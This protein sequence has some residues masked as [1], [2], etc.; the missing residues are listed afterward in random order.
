VRV[1]VDEDRRVGGRPVAG[2]E[3]V[4]VPPRPWE[5]GG[6]LEERRTGTRITREGRGVVVGV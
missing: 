6:R 2:S 1:G 4:G 3:G 5:A